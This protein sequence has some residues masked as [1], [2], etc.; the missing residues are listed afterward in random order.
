[1]FALLLLWFGISFPLLFVGGFVGFDK[2][3][4]I[5]DPVKTKMIL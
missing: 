2:K 4:A 5:E 1:M 3:A